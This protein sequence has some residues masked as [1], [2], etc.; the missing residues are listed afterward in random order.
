MTEDEKPVEIKEEMSDK[1]MLDTYKFFSNPV[2][3][4]ATIYNGMRL[5]LTKI[6]EIEKKLE[7]IEKKNVT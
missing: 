7:A 4:N 3:A 6:T 2:T 5:I 1:D